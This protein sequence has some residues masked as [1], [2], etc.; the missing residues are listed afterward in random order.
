MPNFTAIMK[1][2][3]LDNRVAK[4][5]P[6]PS[7][8]LADAHIAIHRDN[9]PDAFVQEDADDVHVCDPGCWRYDTDN[10]TILDRVPR[11]KPLRDW[12]R[13]RTERSSLLVSSD[14]T[15]YNDSPLDDEAKA[16]WVEYRQLLRDLPESTEDPANPTWPEVPE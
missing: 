13:L 10:E 6:F 7:R 14:W 9:Y 8:E 15:Q 4:Y 3:P 16:S 11:P 5:M 1:L 2:D 12:D